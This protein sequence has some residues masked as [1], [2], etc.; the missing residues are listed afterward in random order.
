MNV[1]P[2]T[3]IDPNT[4]HIFIINYVHS[5]YI[6]SQNHAGYKSMKIHRKKLPAWEKQRDILDALKASQVLVVSGMTG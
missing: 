3:I 5:S 1:T 6:F 2:I 4:C